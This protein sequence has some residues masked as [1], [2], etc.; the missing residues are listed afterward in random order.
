MARPDEHRTRQRPVWV[1]LALTLLPVL[2]PVL[3]LGIAL[4]ITI[5][6]DAEPGGY[7]EPSTGLVPGRAPY[8]RT[9]N[10]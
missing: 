9:S 6:R 4:A 7:G 3:L 2:G 1:R 8:Q 5:A 10:R